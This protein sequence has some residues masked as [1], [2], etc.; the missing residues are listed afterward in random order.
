MQNECSSLL[1]GLWKIYSDSWGF[2]GSFSGIFRGF[3]YLM[4]PLKRL[5]L[6][7]HYGIS[8]WYRMQLPFMRTRKNYLDLWG[9]Q[10]SHQL[11]SADVSIDGSPETL[12]IITEHCGIGRLKGVLNWGPHY[13][14]ILWACRTGRGNFFPV[15]PLLCNANPSRTFM[16]FDKSCPFDIW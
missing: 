6:T 7:Q 4:S 11:P 10:G 5:R 15:W 16:A 2:Q 1:S 3:S 8:L 9:F 12:P 13:G 14:E